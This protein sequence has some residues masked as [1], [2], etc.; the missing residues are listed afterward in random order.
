M[1]TTSDRTIKITVKPEIDA[2][3]IEE[4][5]RLAADYFLASFAAAIV[6][7]ASHSADDD[8]KLVAACD[9]SDFRKDY[10]VSSDPELMQ[11]EHRAFLAGWQAGRHGD[12]SGALR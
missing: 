1:A 8:E 3:A 9:W 2:R 12:Q 10:G 5:A 4:A 6:G 7:V 11:R